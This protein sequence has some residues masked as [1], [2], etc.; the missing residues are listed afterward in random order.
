M[1]YDAVPLHCT[2][3]VIFNTAPNQ[4]QQQQHGKVYAEDTLKLDRSEIDE[5]RLC[6]QL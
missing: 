4:Q 6:A 1:R 3:P 2:Q 5:T